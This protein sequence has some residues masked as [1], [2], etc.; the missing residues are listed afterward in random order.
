MDS[1]RAARL[2]RIVEASGSLRPAADPAA[3]RVGRL[4]RI[5]NAWL[6]QLTP[7]SIA[8]AQGQLT[9]RRPPG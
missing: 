4:Q 5:Q 8:A 1:I 6:H 3:R 9:R 2:A 7:R